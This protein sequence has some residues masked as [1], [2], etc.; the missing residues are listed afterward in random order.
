MVSR[1]VCTAISASTI[2]SFVHGKLTAC[3]A[4]AIVFVFVFADEARAHYRHCYGTTPPRRCIKFDLDLIDL[5][6]WLTSTTV[7]RR[8]KA[9]AGYTWEIEWVPLESRSAVRSGHRDM[10]DCS[11]YRSASLLSPLAI[12]TQPRSC[13]CARPLQ[14]VS[15]HHGARNA[16]RRLCMRTRNVGAR[17]YATRWARPHMSMT[18]TLAGSIGSFDGLVSRNAV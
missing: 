10:R 9:S 18:T 5:F 15:V 1:I 12:H 4:D 2:I 6:L 16:S 17:N 3:H 7:V 8:T 11:Q 13:C 14:C